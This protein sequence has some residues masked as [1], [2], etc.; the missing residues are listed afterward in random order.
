MLARWGGRTLI[1]LSFVFLAFE[2][3]RNWSSARGWQPHV[4]DFLAIAG[5]ALL[6]GLALT[7]LV[8]GWHQIISIFGPEARKRTYPSYGMT[9]I[10]KY[11]PGNVAHLFGRGVY[12]R[13][14]LLKDGQIVKATIAELVSIPGAACICI[15]AAGVIGALPGSLDW[16]PAKSWTALLFLAIVLVAIV[17][18]LAKRTG[19]ANK[20]QIRAFSASVFLSILFMLALGSLY[21]ACFG[22]LAN[23]PFLE[24]ASAAI[25]AW[26]VGFLTPGAPGGLGTREA[27]FVLLLGHLDQENAVLISAALFRVVTILGDCALFAGGWLVFPRIW[28]QAASQK[29]V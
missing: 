24:L 21:A 22:L 2:I 7:L 15:L 13:G 9:Q 6:Y 8:E 4:T 26:L 19:I 10:A 1:A 5:L 16:L 18:L 11:L 14:G 29:G 25:I 20:Q 28:P 12:L 3:Q 17:A 23:A 27:A